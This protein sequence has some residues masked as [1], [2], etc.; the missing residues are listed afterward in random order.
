M[1][2]CDDRKC[3]EIIVEITVVYIVV[4]ILTVV[5]ADQFLSS[6]AG[7]TKESG[8]ILLSIIADGVLMF[9]FSWRFS[10]MKP[11]ERKG[12]LLKSE[13]PFVVMAAVDFL[14]MGLAVGSLSSLLFPGSAENYNSVFGSIIG[15]SRIIPFIWAVLAAPFIEELMCRAIIFKA[16]RTQHGFLFS[17]CTSSLVWAVFHMNLLQG[18]TTFVVGILMALIMEKFGSIWICIGV[19]MLNN[20]MAFL[21]MKDLSLPGGT[22]VNIAEV[23]I[24]ILAAAVMTVTLARHKVHI[25]EQPIKKE[26]L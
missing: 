11:Y 14:L 1:V 26:I 5:F 25:D 22:A 13:W 2:S 4:S 8:V 19:H 24:A 21:P 10:Y 12:M 3:M 16:L 15:S 7:I 20:I 9:Y 17:A 23:A 6:A 18:V